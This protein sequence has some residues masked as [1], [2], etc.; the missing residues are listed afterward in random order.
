MPF[1]F[2]A[3]GQPGV[4]AYEAGAEV[5]GDQWPDLPD[6]SAV[7]TPPVCD[8]DPDHLLRLAREQRGE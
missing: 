5:P 7:W 4:P 6:D 8:D 1:S 3:I 2:T